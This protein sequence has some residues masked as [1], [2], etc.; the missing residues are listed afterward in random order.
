MLVSEGWELPEETKKIY[1]DRNLHFDRSII[2]TSMY[3]YKLY[4]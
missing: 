1:V 2:Y 3:I 4:L